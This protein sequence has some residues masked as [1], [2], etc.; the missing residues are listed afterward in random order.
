MEIKQEAKLKLTQKQIQITISIFEA[1]I[2]TI[3]FEFKADYFKQLSELYKKYYK[4]IN[5]NKKVVVTFNVEIVKH[6]YYRLPPDAAA[7]I[8]FIFFIPNTLKN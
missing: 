3:P 6:L 1:A 4:A 7:F 8:R 2:P 5:N